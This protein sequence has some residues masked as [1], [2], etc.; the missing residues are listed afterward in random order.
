MN[1]QQQNSDV[2]GVALPAGASPLVLVCEHASNFIPPELDNLC[3]TEEARTSHAAWDPGALSVAKTM[4]NDLDASLVFSKVSRLVY[5]C[6][7]PP[8]SP[9]AMRETSEAFEIPGNRNLSAADREARTARFYK[10]FCEAVE[11]ELNRHESPI[12]ITLHSFTPVF[13]GQARDVEIGILHDEDR[14]LADAILAVA[15]AHFVQRNQPYGPEDGVTH[16]L[17]VHALPKRR[18]NVMIEIRNDLIASEVT[19][20]RMARTLSAWVAKALATLGIDT[21]KV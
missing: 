15:D 9:E 4:A 21:C 12:V 13:E 6:N 17:Q 2:V 19:Q 5:D 1:A 11:A 10:P 8:D 14:R 16:T 3:L 7:R 20:E 18:L